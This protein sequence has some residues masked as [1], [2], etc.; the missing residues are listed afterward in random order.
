MAPEELK[1]L[2]IQLHGWTNSP[3]AF[4][5]LMT[6]VFRSYLDSFVI[7]FI[8]DI[9]HGSVGY[10]DSKRVLAYMGVHTCLLDRICGCQFEDEALVA[11]KDRVLA[12]DGGQATLDPDGVLRFAGRIFAPRVGDLIRLIL[13]EAHEFRYTIH[14]GTTK[15]Y[16]D[17]RKHYWCSGMRRD[18]A[19]FVSRCFCCQQVKVEHLRPRCEF[20]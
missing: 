10:P 2:D 12:R 13:C 11:L 14:P 7:V 19:D 15:M 16:R 3:V 17:L 5:D 8:D 20:Q 4:M 6:R 1:E 9:L 18:I